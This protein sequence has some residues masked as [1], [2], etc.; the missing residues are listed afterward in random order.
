MMARNNSKAFWQTNIR[1]KIT[2]I[3]FKQ[4]EISIPS[5]A[6]QSWDVKADSKCAEVKAYIEENAG[7]KYNLTIVSPYKIYANQ[8]LAKI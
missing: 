4:E 5:T 8:T 7:G 2:N 3:T 1:T 6:I